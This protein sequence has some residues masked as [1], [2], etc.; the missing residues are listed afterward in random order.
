MQPALVPTSFLLAFALRTRKKVMT[1]F[2]EEGFVVALLFT[3]FVAAL[4]E[5]VSKLAS[6]ILVVPPMI[7]LVMGTIYQRCRHTYDS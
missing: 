5:S 6:Y 1:T 2:D 4:G 3:S 7:L